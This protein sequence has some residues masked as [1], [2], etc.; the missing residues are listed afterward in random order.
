MS[1]PYIAT[2][3]ID[4]RCPRMKDKKVG[5]PYTELQFR[6]KVRKL[7]EVPYTELQLKCMF[8]R[9]DKDND[10]YLSRKELTNAFSSFGSSV[11]L[12]RALQA[13]WQADSN[14]DG[15][16][17]EAELENLVTYALKQ[18]YTIK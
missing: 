18:C 10:G 5:V 14:G 6:T 3:N 17:S 13:L 1:L 9:F 4:N 12:W 15:R 8:K 16:I 11:P 2:K 7:V